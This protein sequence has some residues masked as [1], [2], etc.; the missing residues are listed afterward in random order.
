MKEQ[1]EEDDKE[2]DNGEEED[3]WYGEKEE[4]RRRQRISHARIAMVGKSGES[5]TERQR[6]GEREGGSE[7][8]RETESER[9]RERGGRE[10]ERLDTNGQRDP[11]PGSLRDGCGGHSVR[12]PAAGVA[13]GLAGTPLT[14]THIQIRLG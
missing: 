2:E 8:E 14:L 9:E 13:L 3:S 4:G 10:A 5:E 7:R 12:G 1:E 11:G 6:E